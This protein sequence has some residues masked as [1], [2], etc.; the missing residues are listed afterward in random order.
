MLWAA[1]AMAAVLRRP[2]AGGAAGDFH[3]PVHLSVRLWQ[4]LLSLALGPLWLFSLNMGSSCRSRRALATWTCSRRAWT[5]PTICQ[6]IDESM[7]ND[8]G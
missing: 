3:K 5:T 4:E 1:E 6:Q 8:V 7:P 2:R